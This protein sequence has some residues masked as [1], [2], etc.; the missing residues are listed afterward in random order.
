MA[1]ENV[2]CISTGSWCQFHHVLNTQK[3]PSSVSPARQTIGN[4][5]GLQNNVHFSCPIIIGSCLALGAVS[6][7]LDWT[8]DAVH[9]L[10]VKCESAILSEKTNTEIVGSSLT[11]KAIALNV[12][13]VCARTKSSNPRK[14][15]H[16]RVQHV[17]A[18][19]ALICRKNGSKRFGEG[20]GRSIQC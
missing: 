17:F 15:F 7:A 3:A 2:F 1:G 4:F 13:V 5:R 8:R 10:Q 6:I 12:V 16:S 19:P 11:S 14:I 9:Q 18:G 20:Y